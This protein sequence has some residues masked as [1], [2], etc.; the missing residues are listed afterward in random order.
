MD[1]DSKTPKLGEVPTPMPKE[2]E[3]LIKVSAVSLN[4][5]DKAIVDGIYE[6]ELVP[7]PLIPVSDA[8]GVVVAVGPGVTHLTEGDRVNSH[9]HSAWV[10]GAPKPDEPSFCYGTPLPGGLAEYMILNAET[11][12]KAPKDMTDEE[13][14][15]LP[16]AA[17]TAW[18]SMMDYGHL[19]PR[20]T[21]LTQG[22]GGVRCTP[23]K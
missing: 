12:V 19:Q 13:A 23:R 8:V 2:G 1:L 22:T 21:V 7:K 17:L 9:L 10:D 14:A 11:A 4:F 15:T 6:P 16:I 5:R 20:Q 3:V 18:Y